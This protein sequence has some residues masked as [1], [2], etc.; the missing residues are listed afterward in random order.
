MAASDRDAP[1]PASDEALADEARA[2]AEITFAPDAAPPPASDEVGEMVERLRMTNFG[3]RGCL[4]RNPDGPAAADLLARVA[5][6][7][8]K[9]KVQYE[10]ECHAFE[11]EMSKAIAAEARLAEVEKERDTLRAIN[12]SLESINL[13]KGLALEKAR[14]ALTQAHDHM[15]RLCA[16]IPGNDE[17]CRINVEAMAAIRAALAAME[18]GDE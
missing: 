10:V 13:S 2:K 8:N 16:I 3:G 18:A 17:A 6:E 5:Q 9:W 14:E 1:P 11:R 4:T 12:A 7:R 15:H